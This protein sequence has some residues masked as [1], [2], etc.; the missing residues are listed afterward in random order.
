MKRSHRFCVR[1][2]GVADECARDDDPDDRHADEAGDAGDGVVD[3]RGNTGVAFVGVGEDGRHEWCD[4]ER[5]P[6]REHE[7][8]RQKIGRKVRVQPGT[9]EQEDPDRGDQRSRPHEQT[10]AEAVG[11]TAK[12]PRQREHHQR[13]GNDRQATLERAV[14]GDLLQEDREEEE[15]NRETC[16]HRKRFAVSDR[17]VAAGE[18]RELEHRFSRAPLVAKKAASAATP[19]TSGR[20]ITGLLQP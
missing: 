2:E 8:A 14:A 20:K 11:K 10:W 15:Q 5:E 12:T 19:A 16:V 9:K 7:K 17:E 4:R 13:H 3:G 1:R 18:E 6:E